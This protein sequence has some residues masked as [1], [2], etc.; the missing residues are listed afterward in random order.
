MLR[1]AQDATGDERIGWIA[2][3]AA[4]GGRQEVE[5]LLRIGDAQDP[6]EFR[7]LYNSDFR[8]ITWPGM[9]P[10][11][12]K[13][14]NA[15]KIAD[16][17][18]EFA[19]LRQTPAGRELLLKLVSDN[20]QPADMRIKAIERLKIN[21]AGIKLLE[22][23]CADNL[24][25]AEL[26]EA[27]RLQIRNDLAVKSQELRDWYGSELW[28]ELIC[29]LDPDY[30]TPIEP[31]SSPDLQEQF[32]KISHRKASLALVALRELSGKTKLTTREEWQ[33]WYDTASPSYVEQ[34]VLLRLVVDH[35]EMV[36]STTV[37]SRLVPYHLGYIPEECLPLYEQMLRSG[38]PAIQ[39][40]ACEALLAYTDSADAADIAID[41]VDQSQPSPSASRQSGEINML[42]RRFADSYFWDTDAWRLWAKRHR[43]QMTKEAIAEE[44]VP[45]KQRLDTRIL[46]FDEH[47]TRDH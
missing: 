26:D 23:A 20:S 34:A 15:P 24:F 13:W 46:Q 21:I 37:L 6:V 32:S 11:L 25:A 17:A 29:G 22:S 9:L 5:L 30:W 43:E 38:E 47:R 28:N 10:H 42:R 8:S 3:L 12:E 39:Y 2:V 31:L 44:L 35:P 36:G 16:M 19:A 40:W 14:I 7:A 18:L 27:L 45:S 41:L 1:K 4:M 33:S